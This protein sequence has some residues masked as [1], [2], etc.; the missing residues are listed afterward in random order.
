MKKLLILFCLTSTILFGISGCT[1]SGDE[2]TKKVLD[3]ARS[4]LFRAMGT[5]ESYIAVRCPDPFG[6]IGYYPEINLEWFLALYGDRPLVKNATWVS[7]SGLVCNVESF[8]ILEKSE[9]NT[10]EKNREIIL[11]IDLNNLT[12]SVMNGWRAD[13]KNQMSNLINFSGCSSSVNLTNLT[14]SVMNGW[15]SD[16]KQQMGSLLSCSSCSSSINLTK[17]TNSVMNGWRSD[18]K[19]QM[20]SLISCIRN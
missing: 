16:Y 9:K 12:N 14:D 3:E 18:Y 13:Y 4:K 6:L 11:S 15:R 17:L 2:V 5:G 20:S 7:P 19:Q 1:L 8:R 10:S